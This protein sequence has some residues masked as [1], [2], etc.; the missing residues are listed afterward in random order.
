MI[1]TKP[2]FIFKVAFCT[3]LGSYLPV[4]AQDA[5]LGETSPQTTGVLGRPANPNAMTDGIA[6]MLINN[7]VT[8]NGHQFFQLFGLGWQDRPDAETYSL[9]LVEATSRQRGS[10]VYIYAGTRVVYSGGLPYKSSQL[11]LVVDQ[12]LEAIGT[13]LISNAMEAGNTDLDLGMEEL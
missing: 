11:R 13:R 6:G 7:M 3:L 12:A 9:S 5:A 8:P 1:M 4:H 10:Q 2:C